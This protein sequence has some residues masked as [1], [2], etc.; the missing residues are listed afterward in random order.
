M[1]KTV[2]AI[3]I[4]TIVVMAAGWIM[5]KSQTRALEAKLNDAAMAA[6]APTDK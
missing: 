3:F 4:V 2:R 5:A 1:T 6:S